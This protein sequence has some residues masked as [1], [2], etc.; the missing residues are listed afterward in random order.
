MNPH[1]GCCGMFVKV[2]I[3]TFFS[4]DQNYKGRTLMKINELI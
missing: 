3:F 1:R 2:N 4:L